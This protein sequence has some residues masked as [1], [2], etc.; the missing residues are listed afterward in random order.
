M[1]WCALL[2]L[3]L[4]VAT[5]AAERRHPLAEVKRIRVQGPLVVAVVAGPR[6]EVRIEGSGD[7]D[8]VRVRAEGGVLTLG[9][10]GTDLRVQVMVSGLEGASVSARGRLAIAGMRADRVDLAIDGFGT[11]DARGVL[12]NQLVVRAGGVGTLVLAG[13]ARQMSLRVVGEVGVDA[14]ALSVKDV[15]LISENAGETKLNVQSSARITNMGPGPV[16]VTG[17]ASCEIHGKAPV[18]C[19]S[20]RD[21]KAQ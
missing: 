18:A 16:S 20:S 1:R 11:L 5:S 8:R 13:E 7:L 19:A 3:L 15:T 9:G 14:A 10:T 4:P 2:L 6:N 21:R 12:A 17:P